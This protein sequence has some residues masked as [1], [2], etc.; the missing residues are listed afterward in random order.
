MSIVNSYQGVRHVVVDN[1]GSGSIT[2]EPGSGTDLVEAS[3]DAA[4]ET[5]LDQTHIRHDHDWLRISFPHQLFRFTKAELRLRV[6]DGLDYAIKTG[7]A[8]VVISAD[9]GRSK[10]VSGSGDI[11]VGNATDLD[12]STGSG[13]ISVARIAGNGSR[14]NSG[15][16]DVSIGEANSSLAAKSGSGD[17]VVKSL[18]G[19]SLQ[20]NSGSGDIAVSSTS[21]SVDVRSASGSLRIGVADN[22]PTWLDLNSVSGDIR[23]GLESTTQPEPGQPYLTLRARTASGDISIY[24]A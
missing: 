12:C 11:T 16:G 21:G 22:L 23:I 18:R 20:A 13:D 5:F 17:V 1:L 3:V 15:S 6:P 10:I 2:V 8:D 4:D 24:R 19:G 14:L 9:I 7:S